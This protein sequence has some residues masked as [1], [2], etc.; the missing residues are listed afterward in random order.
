MET[1]NKFSI[2]RTG[3]IV[4]KL[5]IE[6]SRTNLMRLVVLF[7][8]LIVLAILIGFSVG[9]SPETSFMGD[10]AIQGEQIAFGAML[11]ILGS[12]Y[13]S[14]AFSSLIQKTGRIS[15][16]SLPANSS[17]K[18]LAHWIIYVLLFFVSFFCAIWVAD[19][20][21][22]LLMKIIYPDCPHISCLKLGDIFMAE[23]SVTIA[24]FLLYQ[25]FFFLGS[26]IWPR[27]SFIKTYFALTALCILYVIVAGT[28]VYY[29]MPSKYHYATTFIKS[30]NPIHVQW[31]VTG[32]ICIINYTLTYLRL[33]E[34]EVINRF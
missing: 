13:V 8:S 14:T 23:G 34:S 16:L 22:Y 20:S 30:L 19:W 15:M 24:I 7:G 25:S 18:F 11:F 17:E 27:F 4:R 29:F 5:L 6:Q 3:S 10:R 28:S 33:R 1:T 9:Y 12:I 31:Y 32:L 21:R 26:I 2:S